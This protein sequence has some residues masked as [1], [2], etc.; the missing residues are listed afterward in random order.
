MTPLET[1]KKGQEEFDEL[2]W[3]DDWDGS[4]D[5]IEDWHTTQTIALINALIEELENKVAI[6]LSEDHVRGYKQANEDEIKRL[7]SLRDEL[8]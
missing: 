2:F 5:E 7:T 3:S 6:G 8:V 4:Q 1:I